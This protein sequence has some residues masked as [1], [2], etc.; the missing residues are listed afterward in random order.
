MVAGAA[1]AL[2]HAGFLLAILLA[3]QPTPA[4]VVPP[5]VVVTLVRPE[6]DAAPGAVSG[7]RGGAAG[8]SL[9]MAK[10]TLSTTAAPL[11]AP[12]VS[13]PA[14]AAPAKQP[15]PEPAPEAADMA[16]RAA[17]DANG[18]SAAELAGAARAGQ[19]MGQGSGQGLGGAVGSGAGRCDM[20]ER[21]EARLR[22]DD[23]VR[24]AA[25]RAVAGEGQGPGRAIR[26]W[27]GDWVRHPGEAGGG[28]AAVREAIIWEVGFA[29]PDCRGQAVRG[30]VQ[31]ALGDGPGDPRL[32]LGAGT[33]R[34][35]D[36]L[37]IRR[38]G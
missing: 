4:V 15:S 25:R 29:P 33:W 35:S 22:R 8:P 18:V 20:L 38:R 12:R 16:E 31:V 1:S 30:L 10:A 17:E 23:R 21:L 28:L 19:G 36:L 3:A 37:G 14:V 9:S 24:E 13:P 5:P 34:W 27:N 26:V 32:V 6:A 7:G 11:P 2:A